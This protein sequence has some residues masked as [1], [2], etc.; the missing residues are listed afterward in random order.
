MD[1]QKVLD[2]EEKRR[3]NKLKEMAKVAHAKISNPSSDGLTIAYA[4]QSFEL[5][6]DPM[7]FCRDN[8][9]HLKTM[10]EMCK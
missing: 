9:L 7:E 2:K 5:A 10:E 4:L 8:E 1:T 3:Q 6:K